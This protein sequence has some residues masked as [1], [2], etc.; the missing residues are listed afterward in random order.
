MSLGVFATKNKTMKAKDS[1]I[2]I[3]LFAVCVT[4]ALI[5]F[6]STISV[7]KV[8][9]TSEEEIRAL[10]TE[11]AK[12]A[13]E[14]KSINEKLGEKNQTI[15][16]QSESSSPDQTKDWLSLLDNDLQKLEQTISK[17]GLD[18]LATNDL[19][20]AVL[21]EMFSEF[22]DRKELETYQEKLSVLNSEL[23]EADRNKYD[24]EIAQLYET[25][26]M[27]WGRRGDRKEREAAFKQMLDKYP[28][29]YSTGMIIAEKA[30]H[31]G[32]RGRLEDTEK[33]Y[34]ML[35]DNENFQNIVTDWGV[36]AM[37]TIQCLLANKYIQ[38]GRT[39]DVRS[40]L[41][42]LEKMDGE[43]FMLVPRN[44]GRRPGRPTWK[45]TSKVV[46]KLR[47]IIN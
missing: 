9:R 1:L 43:S 8:K 30:L 27:R 24:A 23:H 36:D 12:L 28:D 4:A 26:R 15:I 45:K 41:E 19:D 33:Y 5:A 44:G 6:N 40:M 18:M 20:P 25:A 14:L 38:E 3:V 29:S 34:K 10:N 47:K 17:T 39:E 42:E 13:A 11:V 32:F 31:S 22:S 21:K 16:A 7:R 37:P 46:N 2:I 35:A